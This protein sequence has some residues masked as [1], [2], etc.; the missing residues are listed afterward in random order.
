M[1]SVPTLLAPAS[2]PLARNPLLLVLL[3]AAVFSAC[4]RHAQNK[5]T[6]YVTVPQVYLRDR[7]AAVYNRVALVKNG[8]QVQVLEHSRRFVR[9]RTSEGKEGWVEERYLVGQDVYDQMQKLAADYLNAP[10]MAAG[11]T[12]NDTNIHIAPGRDAQHLYQLKQ[13]AKVQILKR[14]TAPKPQPATVPVREDVSRKSAPPQ[15]QLEDWWLVRDPQGRVGWVLARM[16]DMDVPLE[17]AQ[18]AEGQRIVGAF[19][20][21]QV[22]DGDKQVPQY[23]MVLTEPHDGMPFDYNQ[24]RVFTWNVKRHRYETAYRERKLFGV[25]PVAVTHETFDKEGSL[26]VFILRV[27]GDSG[28][29][30]ERKYRL[31]TPLVQRVLSP[32][33]QAEKTAHPASRRP[34]RRR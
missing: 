13:G 32:A 3:V 12:D 10:V 27:Q 21:N 5:E 34:R 8:E 9:V 20:L 29:I 22:K 26:P 31:N 28:K 1:R 6:A 25:F 17:V 15:P 7:V 24:V 16:V 30:V 4:S 23:L 33:E 14:A 11:V 18:Y 2:R 19:V